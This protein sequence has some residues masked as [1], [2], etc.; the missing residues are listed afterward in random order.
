MTV[1]TRVPMILFLQSLFN[2]Y[3]FTNSETAFKKDTCPNVYRCSERQFGLK[4]LPILDFVAVSN[5]LKGSWQ[6]V[7]NIDILI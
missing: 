2:W 3:L 4:K 6:A 5:L 7:F 1:T